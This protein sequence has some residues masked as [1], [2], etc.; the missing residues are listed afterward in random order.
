[1]HYEAEEGG[2]ACACLI[3]EANFEAKRDLHMHKF[4]SRYAVP[5]RCNKTDGL[6][7]WKVQAVAIGFESGRRDGQVLCLEDLVAE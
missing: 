5:P 3:L 4:L 6:S 2:F 1:V 7:M